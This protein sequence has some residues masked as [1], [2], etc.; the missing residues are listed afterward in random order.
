MIGDS[1]MRIHDILEILRYGLQRI[2][3]SLFYNPQPT[4][5]VIH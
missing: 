5:S 1:I 2:V 3:L 4:R